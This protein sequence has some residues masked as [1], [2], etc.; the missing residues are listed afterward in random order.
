MILCVM[1]VYTITL[2]NYKLGFDNLHLLGCEIC[3]KSIKGQLL[4]NT[5][6]ECILEAS[7]VLFSCSVFF[8]KHFSLY[9]ILQC[10]NVTM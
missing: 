1:F 3:L 4:K 8:G 10:Y 5:S 7:S 9:S 6:I 2:F